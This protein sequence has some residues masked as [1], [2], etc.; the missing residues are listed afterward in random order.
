MNNMFLISSS[1][2]WFSAFWRIILCLSVVYELALIFLLFQ[3]WFLVNICYLSLLTPLQLV[4]SAVY[5]RKLLTLT[6]LFRF[7]CCNHE[8]CWYSHFGPHYSLFNLPLHAKLFSDNQWCKA[9]IE[10]SWRRFGETIAWAI[11]WGRLQVV[12]SWTSQGIIPY[13]SCRCKLNF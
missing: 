5:I 11:L 8:C 4:K 6:K 10:V 9:V 1:L 3:V 2:F 12:H 7:F 13:L